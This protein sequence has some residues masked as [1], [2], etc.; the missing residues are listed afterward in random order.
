MHDRTAVSRYENLDTRSVDTGRRLDDGAMLAA[1]AS[2]QLQ[3]LD[4]RL[5]AARAGG[6]RPPGAR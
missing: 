2:S 4:D 3:M 6:D 5:A 1:E